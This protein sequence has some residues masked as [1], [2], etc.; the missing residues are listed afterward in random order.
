MTRQSDSVVSNKTFKDTTSTIDVKQSLLEVN[1]VYMETTCEGGW[2]VV[3]EGTLIIKCHESMT[4]LVAEITVTE[5]QEVGLDISRAV[6]FKDS[7]LIES[8]RHLSSD[9]LGLCKL[10]DSIYCNK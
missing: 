5:P 7:T 3:E 2:S 10:G 8:G 1:K 4:R 6:N 9:D